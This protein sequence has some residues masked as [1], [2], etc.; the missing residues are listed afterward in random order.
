LGDS[1]SPFQISIRSVW[2]KAGYVCLLQAQEELAK[3]LDHG[4]DFAISEVKLSRFF[5]AA[6]PQIEQEKFKNS[7]AIPGILKALQKSTPVDR[8][9]MNEARYSDALAV[10]LDGEREVEC[11]TGRIDVL[12]AERVIEVKIS[13]WW[14]G[15]GQLI[16]YEQSFPGKKLALYLVECEPESRCKEMCDIHGIELLTP[17]DMP[18]NLK[19]FSVQNKNAAFWAIDFSMYLSDLGFARF[20]GLSKARRRA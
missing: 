6:V 20:C 8:L 2:Q 16:R 13:D 11:R 15:I 4:V 9:P 5:Q 12:T 18:L 1:T 17:D 3:N 19:F 14:G 7:V 10:L